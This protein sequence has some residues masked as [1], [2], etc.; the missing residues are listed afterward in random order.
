MENDL[1]EKVTEALG[2]AKSAH[3]RIDEHDR[4]IEELSN[5]YI[6][7][8]KVDGKVDNVEK[9]VAEI[10]S[11]LKVVKEKPGK[12]WDKLVS[13]IITCV[14]TAIAGYFIA[15]IGM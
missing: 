12:N 2:S 8:T 13:T 11:D 6:A 3:Y 1:I 7:L 4:K 14:A 5:V 9:D 15:K 10:K